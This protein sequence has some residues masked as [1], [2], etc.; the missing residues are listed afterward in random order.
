MPRCSLPHDAFRLRL[1]GNH[2]RISVKEN[3]LFSVQRPLDPI[4]AQIDAIVRTEGRSVRGAIHRRV[5]D[6]LQAISKIQRHLARIV[7]SVIV[8]EYN[9]TV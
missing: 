9:G 8:A 2:A 7:N 5:A 6:T 4:I 3:V 1:S